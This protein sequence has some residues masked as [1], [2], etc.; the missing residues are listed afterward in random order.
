MRETKVIT[1]VG[2]AAL[3][4]T[5]KVLLN[6]LFVLLLLASALIPAATLSWQTAPLRSAL[7]LL[8]S[9]LPFSLWLVLAL[10]LR[11]DVYLTSESLLYRYYV[12]GR[13]VTT[14]RLPLAAFTAIV[15]SEAYANE[16]SNVRVGRASVWGARQDGT[17]QRLL[18]C[19]DRAQEAAV[20]DAVAKVRCA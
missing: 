9:A 12:A 14:R 5:G 10:V 8:W 13:L 15:G 3:T 16:R 6:T 4:R 11:A 20:M 2:D 1:L 18:E 7:S 17:W 19:R